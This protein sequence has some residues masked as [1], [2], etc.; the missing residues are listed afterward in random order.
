MKKILLATTMLAGTAGFAAAEVSVSGYAEIGIFS[1]TAGDLQ[2]WQDVEVTFGMSGTTDGGLEFGASIDLDETEV[3]G[4]DDAGT[5]VW[6]SGAFG[7]VTMG[8]TDGALDWAIEDAG[9]LTSLADDH[10]SHIAYFSANG[11]D[12]VPVVGR[13]VGQDGQ[14]V[15]YE[16]TVGQFGFALSLEQVGNGADNVSVITSTGSGT[17]ASTFAT[18]VAGGETI[19][20]VGLKYAADLGG[21]TVNFGL[22][23]QQSTGALAYDTPLG[24]AVTTGKVKATGVSAGATFAGGFGGMIGYTKFDFGDGFDADHIGLALN[25]TS[26]PLGLN[27]NYGKLDLSTAMAAAFGDDSVDSWGAAAN[28]DLGGGAKVMFGYASDMSIAAG[29]QDQWSLGL[30]LA[31]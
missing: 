30:G 19:W 9:T 23:H 1:D 5:T 22:G 29:N 7:K 15:R 26:G 11:L 27:V 3:P 16:N 4:T 2:F 17:T 14:I 31:F 28:Y 13:A 18:P 21:T 25:Y 8:D 6:V 24:L 10:T 12:S 20:G